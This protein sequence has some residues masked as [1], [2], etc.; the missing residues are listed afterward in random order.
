[1]KSFLALAVLLAAPM[2]FA[3]SAPATCP[4]G[5]E[6]VKACHL[7]K[8]A[9]GDF[10]LQ[11]MFDSF[12]IC[13]SGAD[14]TV[15]AGTWGSDPFNATVT[16]KAGAEGSGKYSYETS[17][18]GMPLVFAFGEG[19]TEQPNQAVLRLTSPDGPT[20]LTATHACD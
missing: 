6:T 13:K 8:A 7:N 3:S 17:I 1:V 15:V 5:A 14:F 18:E 20:T 9:G 16:Y 19:S 12:A 2:T 4:E 10:L 11:A